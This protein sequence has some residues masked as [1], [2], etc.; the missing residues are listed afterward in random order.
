MK[1]KTGIA[2]LLMIVLVVLSVGFGAYRGWSRERAKVEES[3]AGLES[4]LRTRVE[5]A[6]NVLAVAKRH[7]KTGDSEHSAALSTSLPLILP[8]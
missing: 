4:M 7:V 8:Q 3:Y 1:L 6:Y 5:S 2:F